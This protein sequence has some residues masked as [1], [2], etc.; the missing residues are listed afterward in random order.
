MLQN[1]P[2][3]ASTYISAELKKC[4]YMYESLQF[5]VEMSTKT[6]TTFIH[7]HTNCDLQGQSF[8]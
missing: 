3:R 2:I 6:Q 1:L 7:F 8:D 4:T 5:P